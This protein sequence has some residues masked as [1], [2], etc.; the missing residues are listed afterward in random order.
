MYLP[1]IIGLMLVLPLLSVAAQTSMHSLQM[2]A[3]G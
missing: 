3:L 2:Q 1:A